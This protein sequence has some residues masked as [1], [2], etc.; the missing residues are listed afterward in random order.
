MV[1]IIRDSAAFAGDRR[2]CYVRRGSVVS[3]LLMYFSYLVLFVALAVEKYCC[4]Q[5]RRPSTT[6]ATT[7]SETEGEPKQKQHKQT[8]TPSNNSIGLKPVKQD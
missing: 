4:R 5:Q 1:C 2:D 6:T 7:T 3:G 8:K